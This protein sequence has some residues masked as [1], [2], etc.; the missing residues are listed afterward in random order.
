MLCTI[1]VTIAY[2]YTNVRIKIAT[3]ISQLKTQIQENFKFHVLPAEWNA[4]NARMKKDV[5]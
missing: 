1:L 3:M 4:L 2:T 5:L